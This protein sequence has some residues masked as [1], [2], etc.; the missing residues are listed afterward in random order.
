M[1]EAHLGTARD[2]APATAA[3][4]I[5]SPIIP[6][7]KPSTSCNQEWTRAQPRREM[8]AEN[9]TDEWI[10]DALR[11]TIAVTL[12][13]ALSINSKPNSIKFQLAA[14]LRPASTCLH[15]EIARTCS[16]LVADRCEAKFRYAIWSQTGP[17]L[18]ADLQR[19]G[20][21]PIN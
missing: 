1:S 3:T 16:N 18:V 9:Q 6:A 7:I 14:G 21:W 10:L 15:V 5:A 8:G 20:I 2:I 11:S 19:A 4:H 17:K 12:L 13:I